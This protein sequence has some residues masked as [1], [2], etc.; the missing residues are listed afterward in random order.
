MVRESI[1]GVVNHEKTSVKL[2][3]IRT[4]DAP[5]NLN[6]EKNLNFIKKER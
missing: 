2:S 4:I 1:L 6:I 5:N 3:P